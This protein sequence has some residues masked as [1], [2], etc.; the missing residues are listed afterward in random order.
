MQCDIGLEAAQ[1][2]IQKNIKPLPAGTV[3][4]SEAV[5]RV[6]A[7]DVAAD[8][9]LPPY[10]QSAVD[11]FALADGTALVNSRFTIKGYLQQGDYPTW[12]L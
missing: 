12:T 11:G 3:P 7:C 10:S 6:L 4:L 8:S 1:D 9:N 5:N 2:L